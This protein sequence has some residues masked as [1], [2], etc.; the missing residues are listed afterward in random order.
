MD[1]NQQPKSN[2]NINPSDHQDAEQILQSLQTIVISVDANHLVRRWNQ[3]AAEK[4]KISAQEAE[5]KSFFD[6][7]V[8]WQEPRLIKELFEMVCREAPLETEV[9][10]QDGAQL[11]TLGVKVYT[12]EEGGQPKGWLI[13]AA[14][15]TQQKMLRF[16]LDQAQKMEAVG[17][18]AAGVAHEINTPIQYIGDSVRFV[19]KALKKLDSILELLPDLMENSDE[20]WQDKIEEISENLPSARKVRKSLTQIPEALDDAMTGVQKVAKIV[21]AMK[22]FSHPGSN[23]KATI[24]LN[25]V[26]ESTTTVARNEWKYVSELKLELDPELP[27]IQG[28][29]GELNQAFLNIVVNAAHAIGDRVQRGDYEAGLIQISTQAERGSSSKNSGHRWRDSRVRSQP[30]L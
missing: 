12:Q 19:S 22:A 18:L 6:L 27:T 25:D 3:S 11:V 7:S 15:I 20:D 24:S 5:G 26:L 21:A 1:Q 13:Q 9:A 30:G 17:Q 28:F 23:E 10:F 14:D 29:H 8:Q 16:Q 4:F 2:E